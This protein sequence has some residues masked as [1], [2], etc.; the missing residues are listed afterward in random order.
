MR[1]RSARPPTVRREAHALVLPRERR[2]GVDILHVVGDDRD[3]R[4]GTTGTLR[5]DHPVERHPHLEPHPVPR[6]LLGEQQAER[7]RAV[8]DRGLELLLPRRPAEQPVG[9][10]RPLVEP[11]LEAGCLRLRAGLDR[12]RQRQRAGEVRPRVRQEQ[13]RHHSTRGRRFSASRPTIATN[14][15]THLSRN[16]SRFRDHH[17]E[18]AA[19][20][21]IWSS[22]L[23]DTARKE[24]ASTRYLAARSYAPALCLVAEPHTAQTT[25]LFRSLLGQSSASAPTRAERPIIGHELPIA[26]QIG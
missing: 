12:V 17:H 2:Q 24:I 26:S 23:R 10:L 6:P 18:L 20:K 4:V 14:A 9:T 5:R 11:D 8:R 16:E 22:S 3:E 13:E 19:G 7:A 15:R 1:I 21:R 25:A